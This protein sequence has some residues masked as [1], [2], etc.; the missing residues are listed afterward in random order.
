MVQHRVAKVNEL[1]QG[2]ITRI[3]I[4]DMAICVVHT[5][6]GRIF[7]MRDLCTHESFP[8]SDGWTYDSEIECG[9]HN[10][11]FDMET[12]AV[13]GLP[14]TKPITIFPVSIDGDDVV[15]SIDVTDLS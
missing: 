3:S 13:L 1:V 2:E 6:E 4:G 12:G 8:L 10:A 7:A 15:V 11:V 5:K 9:H 14:A